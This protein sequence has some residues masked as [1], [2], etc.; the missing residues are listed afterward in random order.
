MTTRMKR[1]HLWMICVA[2]GCG[3]TAC[4]EAATNRL[5]VVSWNIQNLFDAD[6]DPDNPFD[7]EYTPAG[8]QN[9]TPEAY[10]AKLKNLAWAIAQLKPDILG[11]AEVE[12][13]RVL[14]DLQQVLK[15]EHKFELPEIIHREGKDTRGIEVALLSRVKP[16]AMSWLSGKSGR[17]M[18]CGTFRVD[19][20]PVTVVMCHWKSKLIPQGMTE[21]D[22]T[23]TRLKEASAV[24]T[25][26]DAQMKKDA[27]AAII[28]MGDFNEVIT[29]P[30]L[31]EHALFLVDRAALKT[32]P[33]ALFNLAS[34]L[35]ERLRGTYYYNKQWEAIDSISVTQPMLAPLT[36]HTWTVEPNTYRVYRD[37]KLTDYKNGS[38][39][40]FRVIAPKE[41]APYT[42]G[43]SDHFPVT[44]DLWKHA[45]KTR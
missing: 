36:P 38:P 15:A 25:F 4:A 13:R 14:A 21:Q 8:K 10:Q 26:I 5:C 3:L 22:V 9:W 7:D 23:A 39:R 24:R 29:S 11:V 35:P 17:E 43:H 18:V 20:A 32:T 44:V 37:S 19:G 16:E 33:S 42:Y 28:V 45:Q 1:W 31:T 2:V 41:R 27:N 12:N 6:D 40:A 34:E 30:T